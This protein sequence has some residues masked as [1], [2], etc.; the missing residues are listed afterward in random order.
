[1][2][3]R[4]EIYRQSIDVGG[5]E[6]TAVAW[7]EKTRYGFRHLAEIWEDYRTIASGKAVYYN[8]TWEYFNGETAIA[9][10]ISKLKKPEEK[11]LRDALH[12]VFITQYIKKE[13][14]H[15]DAWLKAF[16]SSYDSLS[17]KT[18]QRIAN[19]N[20]CVTSTEQ[21]ESIVRMGHMIDV[22]EQ[23]SNH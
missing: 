21:A 1:M 4:I 17:E 13:N 16:K 20:V 22:M 3:K 7:Y 6:Y 12:E 15:Y 2:A 10:A 5:K 23:L 9:N 8:R 14:E 18:K 11:P 19:A